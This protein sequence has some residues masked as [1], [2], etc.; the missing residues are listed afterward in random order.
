MYDIVK[1]HLNQVER[2]YQRYQHKVGTTVVWYEFDRAL[3]TLHPLY[4]EGPE[5][6]WKPGF[7]LH[8][9]AV[10]RDEDREQPREEGFYTGGTTHL[11]FGTRQALRDGMTDP[12]DAVSHLKDRFLWD[13]EHWEV[14]R[15]QISGRLR[16]AEV[17][18]GVDAQRLSPEE[19]V[20]EPNYPPT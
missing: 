14:R 20:N 18:I 17:V 3:T 15:Y 19:L 4:D 2:S 9:L 10:I 12:Y 13:G 6:R 1:R 11:S 5:P 8:V 7:Q 16:R